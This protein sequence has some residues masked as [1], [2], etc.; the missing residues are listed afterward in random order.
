M[1]YIIGE[2]TQIQNYAHLH[3]HI[4]TLILH[5]KLNGCYLRYYTVYAVIAEVKFVRHSIILL[6]SLIS[7]MSKLWMKAFTLLTTKLSGILYTVQ[8]KN[9]DLKWL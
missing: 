3:T 7:S 9:D 4:R 1:I 2:I 8:N 5:S 6:L